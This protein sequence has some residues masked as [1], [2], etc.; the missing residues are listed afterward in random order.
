[1][2]VN[3]LTAALLATT[4]LAVTSAYADTDVT[5][6]GK[7]NVTAENV[8]NG[9]DSTAKLNSN[10]SRLGFKG[11]T[12]LTESTSVIY[13]MEYE[14]AVDDGDTKD[15]NAFKQRN[16]YIGLTGDFGT[17]FAGN[18]DTALKL[19]QNKV[20]VMNDLNGGDMKN[21]LV[22]ETRAKNI[23]NY[24]T[25]SYSGFSATIQPILNEGDN[26]TGED[27]DKEDGFFDSF[28]SSVNWENDSFYVALAHDN[29]V[30]TKSA[31]EHDAFDNTRLVA[32]YKIA[33][34]TFGALYQVSD[35]QGVD[36][37][38]LNEDSFTGYLVSAAYKINK[39][40]K[41][42]G[43]VGQSDMPIEYVDTDKNEQYGIGVDYNF[44][45]ATKVFGFY[46]SLEATENVSNN[47][48]ELDVLG[49]G[50]QH[51]F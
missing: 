34:L 43:Q 36:A 18:H 41:V 28:S 51:K 2:N 47:K 50:L 33:A 42:Y 21:V 29:N 38:N 44:S 5:V 17:V 31:L 27:G 15:G 46:N 39:Q 9:D 37:S 48:E 49:L 32:Q 11:K 24:T 10:A 20:D 26:I 22:G 12:G 14:V 1:M 13:K 30:A 4:G 45:K 23:I 3:K 16:I 7:L 19:S 8:D 25:P 6:Y 40:W 35:Y